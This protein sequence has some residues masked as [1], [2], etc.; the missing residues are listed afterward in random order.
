VYRLAKYRKRETKTTDN[1]A[2]SVLSGG[3]KDGTEIFFVVVISLH[4]SVPVSSFEDP[5][6]LC[7]ESHTAACYTS[8]RLCQ[9]ILLR[10]PTVAGK[11]SCIHIE[12]S[13]APEMAQCILH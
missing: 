10:N 11:I 3:E 4:Y 5:G 12:V 6:T 1:W 13:A 7:L 9:Y 2:Q 8:L